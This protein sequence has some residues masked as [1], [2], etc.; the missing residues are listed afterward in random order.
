MSVNISYQSGFSRHN[1]K[2][3][4]VWLYKEIWFLSLLEVQNLLTEGTLEKIVVMRVLGC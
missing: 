1:N 2:P 3:A 4:I